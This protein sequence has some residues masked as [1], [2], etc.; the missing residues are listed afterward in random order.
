MAANSRSFDRKDLS[1]SP[2]KERSGTASVATTSPHA[3]F[4]D[5]GSGRLFRRS[6]NGRRRGGHH[7]Q[8][9]M[10]FGFCDRDFFVHKKERRREE[11]GGLSK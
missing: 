11:E 10:D 5:R 7:G 8:L 3:E 2:E 1:L 9:V 4:P 6:G